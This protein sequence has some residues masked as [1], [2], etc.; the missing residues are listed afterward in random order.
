VEFLIRMI[1][2]AIFVIG[3]LS[4]LTI[5]YANAYP[6]A[7]TG[8]DPDHCSKTDI[9]LQGY[10]SFNGIDNTTTCYNDQT[11]CH[12]FVRGFTFHAGTANQTDPELEK[13]LSQYWNTSDPNSQ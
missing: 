1:L 4:S 3:A 6:P 7:F 5:G 11:Y 9:I 12:L 13:I 2:L 10:F 8:C